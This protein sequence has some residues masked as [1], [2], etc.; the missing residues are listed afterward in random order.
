MPDPWP[1]RAWLSFLRS[2][3]MN[4]PMS[5]PAVGAGTGGVSTIGQE[6]LSASI[7]WYPIWAVALRRLPKEITVRA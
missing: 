6:C 5:V 7:S 2:A 3:V 4:I 1:E